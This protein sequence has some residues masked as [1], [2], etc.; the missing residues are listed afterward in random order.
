MK[1]QGKNVD[2][3]PGG[4]ADR[5]PSITAT[6]GLMKDTSSWLNTGRILDEY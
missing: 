3:A 2:R 4:L 5:D 1:D 6:I